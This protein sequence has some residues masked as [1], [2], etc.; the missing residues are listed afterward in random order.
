MLEL[1]HVH[2]MA[3]RFVQNFALMDLK[4][5]PPGGAQR[6]LARVRYDHAVAEAFQEFAEIDRPAIGPYEQDPLTLA[7][8]DAQAPGD[9]SGRESV[10]NNGGDDHAE[11]ERHQCVRTVIAQI[12]EPQRKQAGHRD[13][14]DPARRNP[15]DEQLL[16][17]GDAGKQQ[18]GQHGDGPHQE[19]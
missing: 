5:L 9:P 15:G 12:D 14:D 11:D 6:E 19:Q 10:R 18:A 7:H 8:I 4:L 3:M 13:G 2:G 16:A 1:I 17:I